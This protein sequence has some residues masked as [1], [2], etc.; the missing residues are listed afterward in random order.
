MKPIVVNILSLCMVLPF[1]FG[2]LAQGDY[3]AAIA[4]GIL[5]IAVVALLVWGH[6]IGVFKE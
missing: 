1:L 2:A 5:V 3:V 4:P 6:R